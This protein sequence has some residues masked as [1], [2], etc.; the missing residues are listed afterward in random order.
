MQQPALSVAALTAYAIALSVAGAVSLPTLQAK[1]QV[2]Q[3]LLDQALQYHVD[4]R[5]L[6]GVDAIIDCGA[7]L[8]GVDFR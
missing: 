2:W 6:R 3:A 1:T 8:A 4:G 7:L 5:P